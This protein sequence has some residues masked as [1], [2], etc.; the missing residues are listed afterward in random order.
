MCLILKKKLNKGLE[1]LEAS[2]KIFGASALLLKKYEKS[3]LY[4]GDLTV[5]V[6]A[7]DLESLDHY[8][9]TKEIFHLHGAT[10]MM[11]LYLDVFYSRFLCVYCP[12]L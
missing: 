3:H 10:T 9:K 8:A 5:G 11:R 6:A 12:I 1:T 4:Q 2:F 7:K